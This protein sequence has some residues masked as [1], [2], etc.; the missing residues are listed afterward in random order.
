MQTMR[1]GL[2]IRIICSH[3][4]LGLATVAAVPMWWQYLH[5]G[6]AQKGMPW[7]GKFVAVHGLYRRLTG[8][9]SCNRCVKLLESDQLMLPSDKRMD[10]RWAAEK[11]ATFSAFCQSNGVRFLYVQLPK[12]L[13]VNRRMLP[14]GVIDVSYENADDLLLQ[15][16]A[17]GVGVTDWRPRFAGSPQQVADNFYESDTHWNNQASL[18]AAHDLSASIAGLCGVEPDSAA[19]AL[20]LLKPGNWNHKRFARH[21]FGS[22]AKRTGRYFSG[23][24]DVMALWPKFRTDL[25]LSLPEREHE[26]SGSFLEIAIPNYLQAILGSDGQGLPFSAQYAGGDKRFVRLVN[27]QAPMDRKV[28][29]IGDSFS[30]SL[31]TYLWV[32]VREIVSIDPRKYEPPLNIARLVLAERPD[33]VIQMPTAAS[34]AT[35]ARAGEKRSQPAAFDYG[36]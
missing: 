16:E 34:L 5:A 4:A 17:R 12:K 2:A 23:A 29:L 11:M 36:L 13:D 21:F 14:P 25:S 28:L 19:R 9:R 26:V 20:N 3:L 30:R 6:D 32:A 8:A 7:R 1:T 10:A 18:R 22:L 15:L 35:D 33:I 27:R 31:R 24:D